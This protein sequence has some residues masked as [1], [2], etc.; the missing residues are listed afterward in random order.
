MRAHGPP[1]GVQMSAGLVL[2][3]D[4]FMAKPLWIA[5]HQ[6]RRKWLT[7]RQDDR[8]F[9]DALILRPKFLKRD[10]RIPFI[11]SGSVRQVA[12]DQVDAVVRQSAHEFKAIPLTQFIFK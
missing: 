7:R 2:L 1:L 12:E 4:P 6:G 8:T 10:D 9:S 3:P 11:L 5:K